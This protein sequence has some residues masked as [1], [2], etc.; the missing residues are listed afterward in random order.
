MFYFNSPLS[1]A[2]RAARSFRTWACGSVG[3]S[4]TRSHRCRQ[5]HGARSSCWWGRRYRQTPSARR[6]LKCIRTHVALRPCPLLWRVIVLKKRYFFLLEYKYVTRDI[7]LSW[8][9][10][11]FLELRLSVP[12]GFAFAKNISVL[13]IFL[14]KL[15]FK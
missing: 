12:R 11:F 10:V 1:Q 9:M 15:H 2:G 4:G 7:Y 13:V 3:G 14:V 6:A 8:I 5:W